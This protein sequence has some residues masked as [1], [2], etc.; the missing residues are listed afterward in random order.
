MISPFVKLYVYRA[1]WRKN[2]KQMYSNDILV[3]EVAL[4][5]HWSGK[6]R[7]AWFWSA[8][9]HVPNASATIP[10][11]ILVNAEWAIASGLG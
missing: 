8:G 5:N 3:R 7:Y 10:G 4:F 2:V 1:L 6:I 11:V 9:T